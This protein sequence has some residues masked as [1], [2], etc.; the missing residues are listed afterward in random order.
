MCQKMFLNV[1]Q[2]VKCMDTR[3]E[4]VRKLEDQYST[5]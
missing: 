4:N 1:E 5:G 3:R 2:K